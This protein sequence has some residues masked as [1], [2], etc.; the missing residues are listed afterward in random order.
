MQVLTLP[1]S[2]I[3]SSTCATCSAR[4]IPGLRC[5]FTQNI[6]HTGLA[7][8][9]LTIPLVMTFWHWKLAVK[10]SIWLSNFLFGCQ[11]FYISDSLSVVF[12][13]SR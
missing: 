1:F 2:F 10:F 6:C 13:C 12:A 9:V 5:L 7:Q 8:A 4:L 3:F 11:I